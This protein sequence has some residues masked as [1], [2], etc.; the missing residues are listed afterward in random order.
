L[1]S[2]ISGAGDNEVNFYNEIRPGLD[3]EAPIS[4]HAAIDPESLNSIILLEDITE[5]VSEFCTHTTVMTVERLQSQMRNLAKLHGRYWGKADTASGELQAFPTFPDFVAN[6]VDKMQLDQG[7]IEGFQAGQAVIPAELFARAE[8]V[9]PT[10]EKAIALHDASPKTLAHGDVHLKNWYVL[11]SGELGLGDFACTHRGNWG[12][13]FAYVVSTSL[14]P[15]DR[16]VWEKG[17]LRYYIKQL[18]AAGGPELDF[19]EAFTTYRQQ[20]LPALAWWTITLRP[21]PGMPD[22]Q[23]EDTTLEFVRRIT[24]AINDHGTLDL[25]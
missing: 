5:V 20:L 8:E 3:I 11:K 16:R 14:S 23:P 12:R 1:I 18:H 21:T 2:G 17:V 9:W 15:E 7:C 24:I 4:F 25:F 22:M 6:L 19:D 13:D 10:T